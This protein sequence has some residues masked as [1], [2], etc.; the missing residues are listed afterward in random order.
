[1]ERYNLINHTIETIDD[2]SLPNEDEI[3]W[4][5]FNKHT[6]DYLSKVIDKMDIHPLAK[7]KLLHSDQQPR[8]NILRNEAVLSLYALSDSFKPIK[9]NILIG[10]NL[11]ISY[12]EE[13]EINLFHYVTKEFMQNFIKIDRSGYILYQI[14]HEVIEKFLIS[15]DKFADEIE[16]IESDLFEDPFKKDLDKKIF[17]WKVKLQDLR[18]LVEPQVNVIY[19]IVEADFPFLCEDSGFY[20]KELQENY[21]RI[22]TALDDYKE[23]MS[24][25]IDLQMSLKSDR[26]NDIMKILTLIS[27]IFLPMSFIAGFYGMNFVNMPE[28]KW[29]FGYIVCVLLITIIGISISF[30][31][32]IKGWWGK[33]H[34]SR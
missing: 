5:H 2:F 1:M 17:N 9:I 14:F 31:F 11:I 32:H 23:N 34:N 18:Q 20:F 15:I 29:K 26:T 28:L 16:Q 6:F 25:I 30:Y 24:G 33:N 21:E 10:K 13:S 27:A 19:Q 3:F 8:V 12:I 22:I 7:H 4:Y